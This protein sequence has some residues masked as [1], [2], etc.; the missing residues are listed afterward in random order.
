MEL[1]K[2]Y[3]EFKNK[4]ISVYNIETDL[5]VESLYRCFAKSVYTFE[6]GVSYGNVI[7]II[8]DPKY[9]QYGY[10]STVFGSCEYCDELMGVITED[11]VYNLVWSLYK[12]VIW[13][14]NIKS[15]ITWI[16]NRDWLGVVEYHF[17][18]FEDGKQKMLDCLYFLYREENIN[19]EAP[20]TLPEE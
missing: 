10:L 19:Y 8:Y 3:N 5:T 6:V 13:Q 20:H 12:R 17:D 11:D 14:P 9:E 16:E 15:L 4:F 7:S 18:E 2:D 1:F